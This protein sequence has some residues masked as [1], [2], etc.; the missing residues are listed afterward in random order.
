M[1]ILTVRKLTKV[2][3]KT[4]GLLGRKPENIFFQT[5]YGIHTFGMHFPIDVIILDNDYYV[6][7]MKQSLKP[8]KIFIWNPKYKHVVELLVN[9][10]EKENIK[11]GRKI[12]LDFDK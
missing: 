1:I 4:I 6:T 8:N 10:I 11:E 7:K 5:R 12:S 2:L 3:D 9:T